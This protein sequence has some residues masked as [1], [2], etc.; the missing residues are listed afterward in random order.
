MLT[1][2]PILASVVAVSPVAALEEREGFTRTASG[3]QYQIINE[4]NGEKV[5]QGA[6]IKFDYIGWQDDFESNRMFD[7]SL[8]RGQPIT[9]KV[10]AGKVIKGLDEALMDMTYSER[11]RLIVP[12]NLAYGDR[13]VGAI[14]P[15]ATLYFDIEVKPK[16]D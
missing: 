8:R 3:L 11:R 16:Q 7:T 15:M 14:D 5:V 10:G 2:A 4:G 1:S 6:T 12:P 13:S 9:V